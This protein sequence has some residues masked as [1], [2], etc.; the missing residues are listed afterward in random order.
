MAVPSDLEVELMRRALALARRAEGRT[1]PNPMVGAVVVRDGEIVGEGYHRRA[2]APHAEVEALAA[3]G[4]RARGARVYVTLE[5][6]S[7]HGRT[8]P[9]A[10][11]LL[12]AGVAEVVYAVGDPNELVSGRGHR[13]LEAAG[14]KVRAGLCADEARE[15]NLPFF[16]HVTTGRPFVTAKFAMSLDGKI[17][18]RAGDS[19]WISGPESLLRVHEM[20]D[21]SDAILVG[22]RT[23]LTDDPR[24]TTRR[25]G[26][27]D[28][29]HPLRVVADSTGRVPA[30]ARL[31]AAEPPPGATLATTQA[32]P[33]VHREALSRQGVAVWTLPAAPDGRVSL[34]HL[35]DELG[36]HEVL[37]L[38]VEGG[39]E[40]LA[41]LLAEGLVDRLWAITAP[42][43]IGGRGA[44]GPVGGPGVERL[45]DALRLRRLRVE[46]VGDDLWML[47]EPLAKPLP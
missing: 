25:E 30:T 29:R 46:S 8:P 16:R 44:P 38:M 39:G 36:R 35:L 6:C 10:D 43:V 20:R 2:G 33:A 3:A 19:Q 31:Y 32:A 27:R 15:L 23:A 28:V 42:L 41:A 1:S 9:C 22:A 12:Q 11:A 45:A 18:T 40:L 17:A 37:T 21:T 47:F 24:L 7:H 5:P 4:E 26:A 34:S 14:V 13:R